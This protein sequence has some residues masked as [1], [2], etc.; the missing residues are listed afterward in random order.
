MSPPRKYKPSRK[1][2]Q[3]SERIRQQIKQA[4][5]RVFARDGL[6]GAT[7][8]DIV[9]DSGT[10]TGSFYNQFRTKQAVFDEILADLVVEVRSITAAARARADDIE[11]MLQLSYKELLDHILAIEHAL[12]FI[13][14]NQHH[15]RAKL[16]G[17][18]GTSGLVDDILGDLSRGMPGVVLDT[19]T[20][21]LAASLIVSNGIE[22]LLLLTT[23]D[24]VDTLSLSRRMT[25][26]MIHGLHGSA[27][28][29]KT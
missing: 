4:A 26:I 9:A 20:A 6:D 25:R 28:A 7:I 13:S 27:V 12:P 15:I 18:D 17:L 11:A 24:K 23:Q 10:S 5:W 14:R 8:G 2:E 22:A 3:K 19:D 16:H 29:D 1:R 21:S